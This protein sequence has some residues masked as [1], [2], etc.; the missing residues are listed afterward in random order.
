M[1]L[2]SVGRSMG[3]NALLAAGRRQ[4]P[5]RKGLPR[6]R[7]PLVM[8]VG[9][10]LHQKKS[11]I[12][13]PTRRLTTA[14]WAGRQ[15]TPKWLTT[16]PTAPKCRERYWRCCLTKLMRIWAHVEALPIFWAGGR[17]N[18]GTTDSLPPTCS[19]PSSQ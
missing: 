15:V 1:S 11:L 12:A 10:A 5:Q 18:E 2:S 3:Q 9:T 8:P 7:R 4:L 13:R 6:A 16:L 17:V 19:Q 14:K